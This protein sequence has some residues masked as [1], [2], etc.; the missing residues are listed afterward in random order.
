MERD[1]LMHLIKT[2]YEKEFKITAPDVMLFRLLKN[3]DTIENIVLKNIF[4]IY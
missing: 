3:S 4:E 2:K 1:L